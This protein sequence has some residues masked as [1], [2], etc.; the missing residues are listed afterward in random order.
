[1]QFQIDLILW[2]YIKLGN[3]P[4]SICIT[5]PFLICKEMF[6]SLILWYHIIYVLTIQCKIQKNKGTISVPKKNH[7]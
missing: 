6:A 7:M 1:M 3:Q 4:S 2:Q 5:L